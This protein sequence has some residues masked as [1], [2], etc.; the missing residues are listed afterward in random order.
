MT[1]TSKTLLFFGN[2]RL[3]SGLK[4]TNAPVL[5]AL[6]ENGYTISAVISHHTD[7]NSRTNRPLEV[8]EIAKE[9]NIPVLLPNKPAEIIDT[10]ARFNA[11]AAILVAY[12]RIIPQRVIDLFPK[13]IINIHPSL[14]PKYRGP[15][16]IESAIANGDGETGVSIMQLTAGMD[17]G[18]IYAQTRI[19]LVGTETKFELYDQLAAK[20]TQLLINSLPSI[21][22]GSLLPTT[23]DSAKATYCQLLTKADGRLKPAIQ[24]ATEAE[25]LVRAYLGFPKTKLRI[26]SHDIIVTKAHVVKQP[27]QALD[28]PFKEDYL[29]VDELIA[30]SGRTISAE[31]FLRGYMI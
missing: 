10:L 25:R 12:G 16:P 8:A 23:Q 18:P 6:I 1:L 20:S 19:P 3:V 26:G 4:K 21:L 2:E 14:L 5:R 9:H 30:P 11:E 24:T 22:D 31:A 27:S 13:G 17:E 7:G 28:I 15:T 29:S